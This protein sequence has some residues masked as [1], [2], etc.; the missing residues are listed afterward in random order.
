MP[1]ATSQSDNFCRQCPSERHT[2]PGPHQNI[3][4]SNT[5][6]SVQQPLGAAVPSS[7]GHNTNSWHG[8]DTLSLI[9]PK[10]CVT[11]HCGLWTPATIHYLV[12]AGH[13]LACLHRR[14]ASHSQH[15]VFSI[16][17]KAQAPGSRPPW[18]NTRPSALLTTARWQKSIL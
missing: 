10:I 4:I 16:P 15:S 18:L 6:S 14:T 9:Q 11:S 2:G 1:S 5:S 7:G 17:G 12:V 13:F 3:S 8:A